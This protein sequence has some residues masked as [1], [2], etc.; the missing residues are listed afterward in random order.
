VSIPRKLDERLEVFGLSL[1]EL[2]LVGGV[3][4]LSTKLLFFWKW[5]RI[6]SL[7]LSGFCFLFFRWLQTRESNLAEKWLRFANLPEALVRVSI[8]RGGKK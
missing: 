2:A 4:L 5:A 1:F 7:V 6:F 3:F 8:R